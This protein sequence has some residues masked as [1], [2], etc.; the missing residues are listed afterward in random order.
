MTGAQSHPL[1][2][3]DKS[4]MATK[5]PL[6]SVNTT[7]QSLHPT[8]L[9]SVSNLDS[10]PGSWQSTSTLG[11]HKVHSNTEAVFTRE[12]TREQTRQLFLRIEG[13]HDDQYAAVGS[14]R[15]AD[16]DQRSV[17]KAKMEVLWTMKSA[18][19]KVFGFNAYVNEGDDEGFSMRKDE[20]G[21]QL[22]EIFADV[23]ETA[24]MNVYKVED[25]DRD[26]SYHNAASAWLD[27]LQGIEKSLVLPFR[28]IKFAPRYR[29]SVSTP[30]SELN[31]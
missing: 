24:R 31:S 6:P 1:V 3:F 16:L 14:L 11:T 7:R 2:V 21:E 12:L 10:D 27:S 26:G 28:K 13:L 4:S 18:F 30:W 8:S 22:A 25:S 5:S 20:D 29:H 23:C 9:S 15:S 19:D 17:A